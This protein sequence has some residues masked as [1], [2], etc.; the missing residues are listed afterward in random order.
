V[1]VAKQGPRRMLRR[2]QLGL[3]VVGM[4]CSTKESRNYLREKLAIKAVKPIGIR[5]CLDAI[6]RKDI[7]YIREFFGRFGISFCNQT[8]AEA[9]VERIHDDYEQDMLMQTFSLIMAGDRPDLDNIEKQLETALALVRS[10]KGGVIKQTLESE[11]GR[12]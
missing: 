1:I 6:R 2:H 11:D 9:I 5:L 4:L 12:R 7:E 3:I 10:V 8:L